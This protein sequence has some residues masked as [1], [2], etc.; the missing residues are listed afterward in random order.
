MNPLASDAAEVRD[1][2]INWQDYFEY[3]IVSVSSMMKNY[4][5]SAPYSFTLFTISTFQTL[6][7]VVMYY[8]IS[9]YQGR[10]HGLK[11]GETNHGERKE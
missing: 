6:R 1:L 8:V 10:I 4:E 7:A 11:S 9:V 3:A 5:T 2:S